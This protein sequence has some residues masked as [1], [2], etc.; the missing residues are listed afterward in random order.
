[1]KGALFRGGFGQYFREMVCVTRAPV[2]PGGPHLQ[3]CPYSTVFET[4]VDPERFAVLR[5]DPNA[6]HPF[7]LTPPL[8][9]RT[10]IA[11]GRTLEL[12]VALIGRGIEYLPHFIQVLE[13]MGRDGRYGGRFRVRSVVSAA[14]RLVY[15][16]MTR[17]FA[18]EAA[19]VWEEEE[20]RPVRRMTV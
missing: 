3:T 5:E 4:P 2:C 19:P 13:G 20:A 11:A 16:G 7:V 15:D 10:S 8:D 9:A 14:G 1:Y 18:G 12:G 6:P 17:R